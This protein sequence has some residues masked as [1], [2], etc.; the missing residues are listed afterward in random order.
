[1][2]T[3]KIDRSFVSEL[4]D[5]QGIAIVEAVIGLAHSLGLEWSLK[6]SRRSPGWR[7]CTSAAAI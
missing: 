6:A 3:L 2:D 5:G 7:R 1:V 4:D